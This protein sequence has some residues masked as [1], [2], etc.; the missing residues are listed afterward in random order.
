MRCFPAALAAALWLL[1]AEGARAFPNYRMPSGQFVPPEAVMCISASGALVECSA[2]YPPT[3]CSTTQTVGGTPQA[4]CGGATP[5]HGWKVSTTGAQNC[6]V[7]DETTSPSATTPGSQ[8][9][10]ANG[11]QY[12]TESTQLPLGPVWVNCPLTGQPI[13]AQEW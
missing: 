7:S 5:A 10:F 1:A 3:T 8:T 13:S 4:L 12:A 11:G 2:M 6:Y 9:V